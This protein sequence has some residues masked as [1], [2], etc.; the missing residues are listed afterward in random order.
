MKCWIDALRRQFENGWSKYFRKKS[1]N[2][3]RVELIEAMK[4]WMMVEVE[5]GK[6]I[7]QN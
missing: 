3:I 5:A 2:T 6:F 7:N 1:T 4:D